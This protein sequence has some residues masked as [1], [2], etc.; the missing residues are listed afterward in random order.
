MNWITIFRLINE[1]I[2]STKNNRLNKIDYG[3]GPQ[4]VRLYMLCC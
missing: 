2:G 1:I 3:I 4:Y